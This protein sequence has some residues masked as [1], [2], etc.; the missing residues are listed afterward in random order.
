MNMQLLDNSKDSTNYGYK[1]SLSKIDMFRANLNVLGAYKV[2]NLQKDERVSFRM[3]LMGPELCTAY[4]EM[5]PLQGATPSP[6][7]PHLGLRQ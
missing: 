2:E 6:L 3:S 4:W 7:T 1:W 5:Y